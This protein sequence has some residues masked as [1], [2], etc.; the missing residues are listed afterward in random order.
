MSIVLSLYWNINDN[1][2]VSRQLSSAVLL[3]SSF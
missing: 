2:V 3:F 1:D